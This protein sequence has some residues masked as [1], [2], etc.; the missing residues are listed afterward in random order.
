MLAR[1]PEELPI[2]DIINKTGVY[3]KNLEWVKNNLFDKE[4]LLFNKGGLVNRL[5]QRNMYG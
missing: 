1:N 4:N 3:P 5:K 2:D